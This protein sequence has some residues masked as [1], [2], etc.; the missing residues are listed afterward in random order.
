MPSRDLL[1]YLTG[2]HC[3]FSSTIQNSSLEF[4]KSEVTVV[5]VEPLRRHTLGIP[6]LRRFLRLRP[7]TDLEL[8]QSARQSVSIRKCKGSSTPSFRESWI[9]HRRENESVAYCLILFPNQRVSESRNLKTLSL[10]VWEILCDVRRH[11][12]K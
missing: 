1:K 7:S 11:V 9:F 3:F 6:I 10:L 5:V 8:G 4:R 2:K 12:S